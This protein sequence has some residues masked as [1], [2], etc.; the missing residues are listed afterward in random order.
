MQFSFDTLKRFLQ[1][2]GDSVLGVD[3]SSSTIKVVQLRKRGGKAVLE[4][5]GE[6][7]LGPYVGAEPGKSTK[8][9]PDK[10]AA[11]LRDLMREARVTTNRCGVAIPL[12]SSLV[13]VIEMPDVGEDRL[14]DILPIEMR[15]YIPVNISEVML[16]WRIIPRGEGDA[17]FESES[18]EK[19]AG[20]KLKTVDVLV[21][22]IHK[23]T[24][25]RFQQIVR[26]A[27]LDAS[28]LE[29][30][31]FSTV[32]A[33]LVGNPKVAMI[34]DIG[35]GTT[36]LYIVEHRVLRQS[37]SINRGSQDITLA[38]SKSMGISAEKAEELKRTIGVAP[39]G[40]DPGV[41]EII[42]LVLDSLFSEIHRVIL[43]YEK[44]RGQS[45]GEIILS[46][47]GAGLKGLTEAA[48]RSLEAAVVIAD[49]FAKVLTPAFLEDVL[50][51]AGPDF[52]LAVG[53]ALRKL[54]ELS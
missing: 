18:I 13:N 41:R 43:G 34:V 26:D 17:Q 22:A 42:S 21:V 48:T 4:T 19:E 51:G 50:R 32:R 20:K 25:E 3:I 37:H 39:D 46:G 54:E 8:L 33:V 29:V 31:V 2:K 24:I 49:P 10:M 36:K 38:L 44:R 14:K 52:A 40:G 27:D 7:A 30:E 5:Y 47:G 16:D 1:P 28:F 9:P 35:A 6:L 11:A 12:S 45:I 53:V 15:R 23:D